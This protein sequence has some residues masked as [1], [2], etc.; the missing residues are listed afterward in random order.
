MA[1]P[2]HP[3][4]I[5]VV[6]GTDLASPLAGRV[7]TVRG[8][9]TGRGRRGYYV[10]DPH[11]SDD[12]YASDAIYVYSPRR[13][14]RPGQLVE[15][16]GRVV[17]YRAGE[18]ERPTTQLKPYEV[19]VL[20]KRGPRVEPVWV[21]AEMLALEA[22]ELARRL[23]GLEAMLVGIPAG[24]T[25]V[26]PSNAFGDYVCV[27]PGIDALRTPGGGVLVDPSAPAR[28]LP[29]FRLTNYRI[30]PKVNV[31]AR[32]V[33]A[34]TGPLNFRAGSFQ[35]AAEGKVEVED[36]PVQPGTTRLAPEAGAVTIATV[37]GF[38]LDV[39]VEDPALVADPRRD[40]DDDVLYGRFEMLARAIVEQAGGPDIVALQ[41]IQDD[42]GAEIT[43]VVDAG[44][45]Y[46]QLQRDIRRL[47]GPDYDW[48]DIPPEVGADGGQPG[49]NIR[50]AFLF[51][52]ERVELLRP[53][54]RRLGEASEAFDGSRKPLLA[55]FRERSTGAEL[56]VINVHLASKRHQRG[57]FAPT[58]P[59]FDPRE[60]TRIAQAAI[61]REAFEPALTA[62]EDF[63]VTGDFNDFEFSR[64]LTTLC[65]D[66]CVNL[67]D[68]LPPEARYAYN[69]RGQLQ[70]LMHGVVPRRC[71]EAGAVAYEILHG[72]DLIGVQPGSPEGKA[73]D[74]AYVVARIR[75]SGP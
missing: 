59:G 13:K 66:D 22:S 14:A 31:G 71:H 36:A 37:N 65:G 8:V 68:T 67:V 43:D 62:G 47:G 10:Q 1:R 42:D 24:S 56:W 27:P 16:V 30:A 17:D 49:G 61:V 7:V 45:T 60:G 18:Q 25:F 51:N 33:E 11:G 58:E 74:H 46:A 4:P 28:W 12:R 73:S 41:E 72:N 63:Y 19:R 38:N 34:V 40:I 5:H 54:L 15:V 64:T 26:A 57:L 39:Q 21:T 52:P 69:H 6:Q 75:L 2:P 32:L 35:I 29:G 70:V 55:R 48:A 53:T 3:T 20:R 44:E 50:N 9:V 23:N